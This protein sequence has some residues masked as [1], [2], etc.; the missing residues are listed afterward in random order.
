M[1]VGSYYS[2]SDGNVN[3]NKYNIVIHAQYNTYTSVAYQHRTMF[4][5]KAKSHGEILPQ[6]SVVFP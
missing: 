4:T 3:Y 2:L 5:T 1:F 6:W